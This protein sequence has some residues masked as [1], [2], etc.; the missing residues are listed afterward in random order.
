MKD[1]RRQVKMIFLYALL[2]A[3]KV[4]TCSVSKDVSL[5]SLAFFQFISAAM[6]VTLTDVMDVNRC[7]DCVKKPFF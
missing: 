2:T 4:E 1:G 5:I 3:G 6:F 7:V